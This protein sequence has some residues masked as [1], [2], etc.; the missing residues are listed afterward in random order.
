MGNHA[1]VTQSTSPSSVVMDRNPA[2]LHS[3]SVF[4]GS[5]RKCVPPATA[6]NANAPA[7]EYGRPR[8]AVAHALPTIPPPVK[9][10]TQS[11]FWRTSL[12]AS[13]AHANEHPTSVTLPATAAIAGAKSRRSVYSAYPA[14]EARPAANDQP[15]C[16]AT[17]SRQ[18]GLRRGG[19]GGGRPKRDPGGRTG[20]EDEG[21]ADSSVVDVV[22]VAAFARENT[23]ID[24]R[25][26][27]RASRSEE[28]KVPTARSLRY[29]HATGRAF[30]STLSSL[31]ARPE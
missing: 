14:P 18:P 2:T 19:R 8:H 7:G 16:S 24:G 25:E 27:R 3:H 28:P 1:G 22:D 17:R 30:S 20:G 31:F 13:L 26:N 23:P 11:S 4:V 29:L 6:P 15:V 12:V 21:G 5:N 10:F 9:E